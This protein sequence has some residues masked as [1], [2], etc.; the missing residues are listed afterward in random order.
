MT[1]SE[2]EGNLIT[3]AANYE[4]FIQK[5]IGGIIAVFIALMV[6]IPAVTSPPVVVE[7]AW[8]K[9]P[10]SNIPTLWHM[11]LYAGLLFCLP[12]FSNLVR[13][14]SQS[15]NQILGNDSND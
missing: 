10:I 15:S 3:S 11:L 4:M 13:F 9:F 8:F 7:T 5:L 14:A 6:I 12:T 1:D 2:D